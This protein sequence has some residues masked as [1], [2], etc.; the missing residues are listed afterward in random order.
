MIDRTIDAVDGALAVYARALDA[1]T[2][3]GLLVG[4]PVQPVF[5]PRVGTVWTGNAGPGGDGAVSAQA[6][7][8]TRSLV[9]S[10]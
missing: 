7:S 9:A 10:T 1:G 2:V 3:E 6:D 8:A 5:R 4:R